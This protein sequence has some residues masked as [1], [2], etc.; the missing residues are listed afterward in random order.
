MCSLS[1]S[2]RAFVLG[3]SALVAPARA[4]AVALVAVLWLLACAP[5]SG[6]PPTGASRAAPA[7][8]APAATGAAAAG[9][10][11]AAAGAPG[12]GVEDFYRGKTIRVIVGSAAGGGF[13]TYARTIARY[14]GRYVPGTPNVIVENMPGAGSSSPPTTSPAPRRRMARSS[15][16]P[17]AA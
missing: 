7:T 1:V 9:S 17:R 4:L 8:A 12:R 10:G 3:L 6:A 14:F 15:P 13:D 2:R 16:T 5:S 11:D